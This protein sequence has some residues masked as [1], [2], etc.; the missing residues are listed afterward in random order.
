MRKRVTRAGATKNASTEGRVRRE[1]LRKGRGLVRAPVR[2]EETSSVSR[3]RFF[4]EWEERWL[5]AGARGAAAGRPAASPA[6]TFKENPPV[7]RD[8]NRSV[9]ARAKTARNGTAEY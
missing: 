4:F 1:F 8:A 2:A 3:R 9:A 7:F 5:R 6:F